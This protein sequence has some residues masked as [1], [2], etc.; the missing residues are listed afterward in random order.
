MC[1]RVLHQARVHDLLPGLSSPLLFHSWFIFLQQCV[2]L[3]WYLVRVSLSF[4]DMCFCN[5]V[6]GYDMPQI[7]LFK[8]SYPLIVMFS[9]I[10]TLGTMRDSNLG[11]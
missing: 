9:V 1:A 8:Y 10:H 5:Q 2:A 7:C 11:V 3:D 6:W 4:Q